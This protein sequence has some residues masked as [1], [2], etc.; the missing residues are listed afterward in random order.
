LAKAAPDAQVVSLEPDPKRARQARKNLRRLSNAIVVEAKSWD[1]KGDGW[2]LVFV[3]GAHKQC[4]KDLI[5]YDRL[6]PGGLILF[7]DYVNVKFPEVGCAIDE[8]LEQIGKEKPDIEVLADGCGGLA[9]IY[10]DD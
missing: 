3:D 4:W 8:L 9:G 2:D 6:L 10:R 5:Y 1:F 7:H